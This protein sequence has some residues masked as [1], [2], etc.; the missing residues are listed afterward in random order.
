MSARG[1]VGRLRG[2]ARS[3][4]TPAATGLPEP[5]P[6]PAQLAP[7]GTSLPGG[8][9]RFPGRQERLA[10]DADRVTLE[11]PVEVG[12][13]LRAVLIRTVPLSLRS[14]LG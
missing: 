14:F 3:P 7:G 9:E 11:A 2:R 10:T 12:G 8:E 5:T 6:S 4:R 13:P 1:R